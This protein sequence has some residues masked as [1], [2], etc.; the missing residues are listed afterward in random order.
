MNALQQLQDKYPN[1]VQSLAGKIFLKPAPEGKGERKMVEE[2]FRLMRGTPVCIVKTQHEFGLDAGSRAW[3]HENQEQAFKIADLV[4]GPL[5]D[6]LHRHPAA[7][8]NA[9]NLQQVLNN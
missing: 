9:D 3:R 7:R 2:L 1:P 4:F 8:I 5:F 6:W